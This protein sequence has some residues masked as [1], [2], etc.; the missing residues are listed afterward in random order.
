MT[1][2]SSFLCLL[3]GRRGTSASEAWL[4]VSWG[5]SLVSHGGSAAVASSASVAV[6]L[7]SLSSVLEP[8][9][10]PVSHRSALHVS[11]GLLQGVWNDLG[12]QVE[13]LPQVLDALVGQEPVVVSP[14]ELLG[15]ELL[16]LEALHELDDLEVGHVDHGV[17]WKVEVLLS[18]QDSLAEEELVNLNPV[19]L[20][21]QHLD[22][23][24]FGISTG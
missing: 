11:G 18:V 23:G 8:P 9:W 10:W 19:L 1:L 14:G 24:C 12:R 7:T 16:R 5:R 20:R 4:E 21:N 17:L 13:V 22:S 15:D 3:R 6:S 2:V